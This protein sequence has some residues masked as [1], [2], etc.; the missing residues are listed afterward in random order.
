MKYK[1]ITNRLNESKIHPSLMSLFKKHLRSVPVSPNTE[2]ESL[3]INNLKQ[4]FLP[5]NLEKYSA[6]MIQIGFDPLLLIDFNE[7]N[8]YI[9][10][11]I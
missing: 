3:T 10:G 4:S 8:S 11:S 5:D 9:R 7:S 2:I 6:I 1:D